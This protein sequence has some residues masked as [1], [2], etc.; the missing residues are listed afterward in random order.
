MINQSSTSY[1]MMVPLYHIDIVMV[2]GFFW[3][4]ADT[5]LGWPHLHRR[6]L[7]QSHG[8]RLPDTA[9]AGFWCRGTGHTPCFQQPTGPP[10]C[11]WACWGFWDASLPCT[12][13]GHGQSSSV[14]RTEETHSSMTL[15][16]DF[17]GRALKHTMW[18]NRGN[19]K[20]SPKLNSFTSKEFLF[21]II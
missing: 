21:K 12:S 2:R 5:L 1:L 4:L 14:N 15:I 10:A 19:F 20:P 11:T 9:W 3:Q 17:L 7:P 16:C 8:A 13:S 18:L 6:Q